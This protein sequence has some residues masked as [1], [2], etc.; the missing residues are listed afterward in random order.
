[1]G[2]FLLFLFASFLVFLFFVL[3]VWVVL[4][5]FFVKLNEISF[6]RGEKKR[7]QDQVIQPFVQIRS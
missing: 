3:F 5:V 1:M 7:H 2:F 4:F 6:A